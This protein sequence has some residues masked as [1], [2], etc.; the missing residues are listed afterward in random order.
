MSLVAVATGHIK[1]WTYVQE[2]T[3]VRN[4]MGLVA[5]ATRHKPHLIEGEGAFLENP[6]P[7]FPP[8][9]IVIVVLKLSMSSLD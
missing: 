6:W 1:I 3:H 9:M 8:P 5:V 4:P 7:P 2:W